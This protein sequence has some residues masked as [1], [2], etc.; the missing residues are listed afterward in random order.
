MRTRRR[1]IGLWDLAMVSPGFGRPGMGWAFLIYLRDSS[2]RSLLYWTLG[3][4]D[5]ALG[6][7]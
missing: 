7:C 2:Y 1:S 4:V 5:G 3:G 6:V